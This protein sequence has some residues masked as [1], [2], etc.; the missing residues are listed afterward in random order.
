[1][2]RIFKKKN[3]ISFTIN[4]KDN[5]LVV[6]VEVKKERFVRACKYD[7]KLHNTKSII[8]G[9]PRMVSELLDDVSK[10]HNI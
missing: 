1:M 9:L 5:L 3:S 10:Y 7:E 2:K 4:S 8:E 6:S